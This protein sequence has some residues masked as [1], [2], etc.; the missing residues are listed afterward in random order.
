MFLQQLYISGF[1][2]LLE[3]YSAVFIVCLNINEQN[4]IKCKLAS[5]KSVLLL[6]SRTPGLKQDCGGRQAY[7]GSHKQ[8]K[9]STSVQE[10]H[11]LPITRI[12]W[13]E[14]L[15]VFQRF[16]PVLTTHYYQVSSRR[17]VDVRIL[18]I[19]SVQTNPVLQDSNNFS[20]FFFSWKSVQQLRLCSPDKDKSKIKTVQSNRSFGFHL[21]FLVSV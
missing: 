4:I 10:T 9:N 20:L 16:Y 11:A 6:C 17:A 18:L 7:K 8:K 21:G 14:Y 19:C 3:L 5:G 1:F 2:F 13:S 12:V 15:C